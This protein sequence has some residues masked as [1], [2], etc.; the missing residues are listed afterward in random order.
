M[1]D[2]LEKVAG[3]VDFE[4]FRPTLDTAI[5]REK[6]DKGGRPPMD[7]MLMFKIMLLQEWYHIAD[8]MTEYLINDRLSF[9]RFLGL[10]LGDKVP[11]AKTIWLYREMLKNSGKS[12]ELFDMFAA[13]MEQVGVIT[14]E[15][16]IVDASFVDVP[17]QRNNRDE[18]KKIKEGDGEEL[19]QDNEN[20]RCQKDIDA[21]WTEKNGEKHFGYKDHVKVDSDSKMIVD[22]SVTDA[23]VHDSQAIV[24]LIDDKDNVLNADSAYTGKELHDK[25]REKNPDII[26]NIHEKGY[27]NKPLSEEQKASNKEKSKVR[28]RVE[29]VFGHMTNSM[30]GMTT[31]VIGI[32]RT[33]CVITLKNLAYNL[34]RWAYLVG[35]KKAAVSI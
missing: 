8:D 6:G 20:K 33:T 4:I 10:S 16:S 12:K 32:D 31:R 28:A 26:L 25:I 5:P 18:N 15:G 27:R 14:R 13:L 7:N 11:D 22:F 24:D 9:Q 1:G 34:S 35:V 30:G 23:A 2:P 29:H 21:R 3:A 17:K 19:W